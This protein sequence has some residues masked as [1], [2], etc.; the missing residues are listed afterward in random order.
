MNDKK[1]KMV[2]LDLDGTTLNQ[3][4]ALAARTKEAFKKAVDEGIHI[5]IST[6]RTF[7]SL[8]EELF[9]LEG[10]EYVVTSNGAQIT[11]L[12]SMEVIYENNISEEA[13]EAVVKQLIGREISV[14]TFVE[15]KA[16]IDEKEYRGYEE[17]GSTYRDVAYVLKTR[18]P[19]PNILQFMLDHKDQ[20]E[21]ISLNFEFDEEKEAMKKILEDI[22]GI[23]ITS[24]FVHNFEIGGATTSK[25]EA[26]RFLMN[27]LNLSPEELMA[28]GDSHN[29]A[30]MLMLA[31]IGVAVD[32]ATDD[33][34][35]IAD[36]I[37][38][39]HDQDGVAKAIERFALS[40]K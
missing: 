12:S 4:G 22:D 9:H 36:Y 18:N 31:G 35:N 21:N 37:T 19:I 1:I 20:I 38:D 17:H 23:T 5:V 39:H 32:N 33:I 14:E 25:G 40:S 30:Q 2:A 13:V 10:L 29:D 11:E 26:L 16:Y 27:Q 15:G 28:C 8:P 7:H 34:K 6:G 3:H 24:S